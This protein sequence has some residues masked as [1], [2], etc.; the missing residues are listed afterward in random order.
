MLKIFCLTV[1]AEGEWMEANK[2]VIQEVVLFDS[3]DD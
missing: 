1:L 3:F 2:C